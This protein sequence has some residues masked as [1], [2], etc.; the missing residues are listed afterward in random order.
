MSEQK[1]DFW[2]AQGNLVQGDVI[3]ILFFPLART[4]P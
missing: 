4:A 1:P 2:D 3:T